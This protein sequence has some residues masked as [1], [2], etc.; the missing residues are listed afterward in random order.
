[1]SVILG[2]NAFHPGSSAALLID[3]VP[4][5][6][7]AEERLNRVKYYAGFPR[8]AIQRCL[9]I[10]GASLADVDAVAVAHDPSAN[11]RQKALYGLKH[12]RRVL[13][14]LRI[15]AARSDLTDHKALLARE[16]E[17]DPT[18]LRFQ[19][20]NVEH[21]LAHIASA[22]FA[23]P[24]EQAAGVSIDGSGDFVSCM[25]ADCQGNVINVKQRV[26]VP[27]S[28]GFLYTMGC[29][30]IGYPKYGD[31]EGDGLAPLGTDAFADVFEEMVALTPAGFRLEP[32]Y[33]LPFGSNDGM[34]IDESGEVELQRFFS[35]AM[36]DRF[37][38]P[39]APAAEISRRDKDLAWAL[40]H[41]FERAYLHLLNLLHREAPRERVALAGGCALN[42]V[43]NGKVFAE[44]PF[45]ETWIQPAA[46]D[47]GLALGAA[48]RCT[49]AVP[50]SAVE[51]R[52]AYLG[53]NT[54]AAD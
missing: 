46:G 50:R 14:L 44:T 22:F 27:E 24:W 38:V 49:D 37:G 2:L 19:Q 48:L 42:S 18:H 28:L 40:Q 35:R 21:H 30:F 3:G 31:E 47:D 16:L 11:R 15:R 12:P 25:L 41:V 43:A 1:L 26:F 5:A 45:G 51:M 33:F 34:Q 29:Q 7:I 4:V 39:R 20:H 10:A 8:L 23:S 13:N 6:A 17:C 9:A 36:V 54:P 52:D 53:P 32:K